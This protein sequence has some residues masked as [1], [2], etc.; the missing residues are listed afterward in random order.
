MGR[1]HCRLFE[2]AKG[3]KEAKGEKGKRE[4]KEFREF[5]VSLDAILNNP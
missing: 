4:F 5:S 3:A 1:T 2:G